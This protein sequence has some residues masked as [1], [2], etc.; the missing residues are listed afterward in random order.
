LAEFKA[1]LA[2]RQQHHQPNAFDCSDLYFV[3]RLYPLSLQISHCDEEI[4]DCRWLPIGQLITGEEATLLTQHICHV[5]DYG[6]RHGFNK[7]DLGMEELPAI[8]RGLTYKLFSRKLP[9]D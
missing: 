9:I 6:L 8:Y 1:L 4:L 5:L 2:V 3:C 7:V